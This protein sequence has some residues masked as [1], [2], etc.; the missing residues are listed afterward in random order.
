VISLRILALFINNTSHLQYC[1][2]NGAEK[3]ALSEGLTLKYE[4]I[5]H[6]SRTTISLCILPS[7]HQQYT[8]HLQYCPQN[9]AEKRPFQR[10]H[11]EV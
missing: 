10:T 3:A 9:G 5:E 4:N 8:S 1:P 2:Q 7:I 11:L 6:K